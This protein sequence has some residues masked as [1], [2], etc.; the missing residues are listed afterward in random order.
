[1]KYIRFNFI[2]NKRMRCNIEMNY[3]VNVLNLH[4][5]TISLELWDF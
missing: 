2:C 3:Q 4:L 5:Q 1:M